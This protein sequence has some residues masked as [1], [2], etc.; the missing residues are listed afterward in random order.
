MQIILDLYLHHNIILTLELDNILLL[1]EV[2]E[3]VTG[4]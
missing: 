4:I 2:Y 1:V 3:V